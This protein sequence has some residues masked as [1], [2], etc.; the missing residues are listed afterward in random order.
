MLTKEKLNTLYEG[1]I[2]GDI[3]TR[4]QI[5]SYGFIKRDVD[6]LLGKFYIRRKRPGQYFFIAVD[7]LY[8]Y[9][10]SLTQ[11]DPKKASQCF[12]V[13]HRLDP[14]HL[15]TCQELLYRR[16]INQDYQNAYS[17]LE[18][19]LYS[20]IASYQ[21]DAKLFLY[22][23]GRVMELPI[24]QG[25]LLKQLKLSDVAVLDSDSRYQDIPLQNKLRNTILRNEF[26]LALKQCQQYFHTN[27]SFEQALQSLLI[28]IKKKK[29]QNNRKLLQ[30]IN[31]KNYQI[32][33]DYLENS[34]Y[35]LTNFEHYQL[36]LAKTIETIKKTNQIPK[37]SDRD[38]RNTFEA[39]DNKNYFLALQLCKQ[40]L[41]NY[42]E[43]F[44][45]NPI[46]LLLTDLCQLIS[47][48]KE[49]KPKIGI[50]NSN[51]AFLNVVTTLMK[52]EIKEALKNIRIYLDL[53]GKREYEFLIVDLLKIS[54]LNQDFT[55]TK[56]IVTLTYMNGS[57]PFL[58]IPDYLEQLTYASLNEK[59][60]EMSIYLHI[61]E[62]LKK[63]G[64]CE[65]NL[66]FVKKKKISI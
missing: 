48:Y 13:C 8:E 31:K 21:N 49:E 46:Y 7:Q 59:Q 1:V 60:K 16:M 15:D 2:K 25:L 44:I 22:L 24:D 10:M 37:M 56:P 6:L 38:S 41:K 9:G 61:L 39:I 4:K 19:L 34:Q 50:E 62:N 36:E 65:S 26:A 47:K 12:E 5:L 23:L 11:T 57:K 32:F 66:E 40:T 45:D 58:D 63:L 27:S 33:I 17:Y 53:I 43:T 35:Q 51:E 55:F 14:N 28:Q 42:N 29:K 30:W 52:F 54:L 3:L 18:V 64:K 20:D